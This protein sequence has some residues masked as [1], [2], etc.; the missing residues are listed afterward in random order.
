MTNE[1]EQTVKEKPSIFGMIMSPGEQFN[2]IREN[3]KIL[4]ALLIVT[5]LTTI[6]SVL[7]MNS[8]DVTN[9]PN[10]VGMGEE[11]L[12][13]VT[14]FSQITLVIVG[15]LSPIFIVLISTVI[16]II[17]AKISQS[18]VSFKQLFSMNTYIF[19]ISALSFIVNGLVTLAIGSGNPE[20]L[21]TSLNSIIGAEGAL[22]AFL[23]S[24][25]VF[26]IW[27]MI[28]TALGLQVVAR[29]SKVLSWS[30]V[31]GLFVIGTGFSMASA[32]FTAMLGV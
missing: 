25:E 17:V 19:M 27:G 31:I 20:I 32:G 16:H 8:I 4:V 23:N 26:T 30:V 6:G 15:L 9:D 14:L 18:T 21:F 22:G 13:M 28:I 7:M 12:M 10:I 24:I 5:A 11:E 29:F 2:R 3:P 1:M